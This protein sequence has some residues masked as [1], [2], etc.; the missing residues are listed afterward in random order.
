M[1]MDDINIFLFSFG[2][3]LRKTILIKVL[4]CKLRGVL[5][6]VILVTIKP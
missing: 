1:E 2:S 4:V 6:F 3:N 5:I